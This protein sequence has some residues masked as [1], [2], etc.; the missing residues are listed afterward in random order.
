M[1]ALGVED[2]AFKTF[3]VVGNHS[4]NIQLEGPKSL[5]AFNNVY[6]H[7]D[8]YILEIWLP[9]FNACILAWLGYI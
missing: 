7:E 9:R 3:L 1:N 4:S 6:T 2:S 8:V 5:F